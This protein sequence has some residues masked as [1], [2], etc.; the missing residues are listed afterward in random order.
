[1]MTTEET[2]DPVPRE[3]WPWTVRALVEGYEKEAAR[4]LAES[5]VNRGGYGYLDYRTGSI[6]PEVEKL[7]EVVERWLAEPQDARG[8]KFWLILSARSPYSGCF[9]QPHVWAV[10]P[11]AELCEPVHAPSHYYST[12]ADLPRFQGHH[13]LERLVKFLWDEEHNGQSY[14][15][16]YLGDW[17]PLNDHTGVT[18][19]LPSIKHVGS[20]STETEW[21]EDDLPWRCTACEEEQYG[22]TEGC[23]PHITETHG[24]GGIAIGTDSMICDECK[25]RGECPSCRARGCHL[26]EAWD[27]EVYQWN[28]Y[29]C[30]WCEEVLWKAVAPELTDEAEALLDAA[31]VVEVK[32]RHIEDVDCRCSYEICEKDTEL[33][34]IA[35]KGEGEAKEEHQLRAG[36][37]YRIDVNAFGAA[38]REAISCDFWDV[39]GPHGH[40][41]FGMP[42]P[43]LTSHHEELTDD[44]Q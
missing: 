17:E 26:E 7:A 18:Y 37:D 35:V 5:R 27:P 33:L 1:M 39:V 20:E 2:R 38:L 6:V 9:H 29:L 3:E 23:G 4:M 16:L 14:D 32:L 21:E 28:A 41:T 31:D 12:Q 42:F 43:K 13:A 40:M 10:D 30:E 44:Q 22:S 19:A 25:D 24:M 8:G 15:S 36:I 11:V 34:L